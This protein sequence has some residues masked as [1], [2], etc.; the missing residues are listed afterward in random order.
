MAESVSES[1]SDIIDRQ[2]MFLMKY[3][4]S[5]AFILNTFAMTALLIGLSLA[6]HS[7]MAAEVGIVQG[8]TLALFF[9]FSANARSMILNP[10]SRISARALLVARLV[11]LA[12]LSIASLYL[13]VFIADVGE[14][15]AV[16]LILRRCAEWIGELHLSDMEL[17]GQRKL[18]GK[19]IVL[20][21]ILL[22]LALGWTLAE[23]PIPLLGLFLWA[24]LPLL[25]SLGF[26]RKHLRA[27][28]RLNAA[29]PQML[30]QFGS[31]AIIG[32]TVYV[33]RLLILLIVGKETAGDLY[34][35]FAIGGLF[36]SIFSSALG[37]SLVLQEARSGRR[38]FSTGLTISLY[39][40]L[41]AGAVLFFVT[42]YRID[43]LNWTGK[44][45]F[46]WGAT[47][48]SMIGGVIMVFAQRI[49]LRLLQLSEDKDV[50]GADV[51]MNIL[52]L[53]AVPYFHYFGD[54]DALMT[55][56]L[57]SSVL[58]LLFYFSSER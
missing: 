50:F 21:S 35:A 29:W 40:W 37:P 33:F 38:H 31:T 39:V 10:S 54:K 12:P 20:Q 43:A 13:S 14:P 18:A 49:R 45:Y 2:R 19:F 46:F 16:V 23:A 24:L 42:E 34:A 26:I 30:P 48:L 1:V 17:H 51:L 44:S 56:Y 52:V 4:F 25:M 15:L 3:L 5:A 7:Q 11:L 57:F 27:A 32:I 8:A 53:A 55:L 36:G 58:A 47:G 9:S 6:K 28:G 22:F 41:L